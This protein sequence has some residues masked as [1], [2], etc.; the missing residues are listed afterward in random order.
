MNG[1]HTAT[2]HLLSI[3][4]S[5]HEPIE[6][7]CPTVV[8]VQCRLV[9]FESAID[10]RVTFLWVVIDDATTS[11]ESRRDRAGVIEQPARREGPAAADPVA[12]AK[13][14]LGVLFRLGQGLCDQ[15]LG[16]DPQPQLPVGDDLQQLAGGE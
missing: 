9:G 5:D 15:D 14:G 1:F 7:D 13:G 2:P 12:L 6:F 11:E 16:A 3:G 4:L 10:E 8:C